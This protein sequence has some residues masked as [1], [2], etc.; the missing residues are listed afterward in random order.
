M[1]KLILV[2]ALATF[3]IGSSAQ[4][5]ETAIGLRAGFSTGVTAKHFIKSNLA[6][7]GILHYKWGL[8]LGITGLFEIHANAFDVDELYWFYG[9]GGHVG[10]YQY[11]NKAP[12]DEPFSG[13]TAVIG[14]DGIIGIEYN[15]R[16]IPIAV[17]VDW[18]PTVNLVGLTGPDFDEGALSVRYTF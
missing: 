18:K 11:N 6:L 7:E 4:A 16:E 3:T 14:I 10:L 17:S 9:A 2:A 13:T 8:G 5:Y 15:I 12:F 1:K